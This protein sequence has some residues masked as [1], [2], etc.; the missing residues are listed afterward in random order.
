MLRS[1]HV[2]VGWFFCGLVCWAGFAPAPAWS[3]DS[4]KPQQPQ[5]AYTLETA[6]EQLRLYPKDASLQ[7]I[8][9]QLARREGRL[10]EV[11]TEFERIASDR[12]PVNGRRGDIDLFSIFTGALAVQE[13]LQLDTMRGPQPRA[14]RM[15]GAGQPAPNLRGIRNGFLGVVKEG[16]KDL[17][18]VA[19]LPGPTIKSHPWE[20][21][22][23]GQ[24][25]DVGQLSKLVPDDYFFAEFRSLNKCLDVLDSG[26][27]WAKH[28]LHQTAGEAR[29][30]QVGD[31]LKRQLAVESNPL[32]RPFYDL[33]VE[34]V[35]FTG[36]DLF[37][38]EGSD[39]T[40]LFRFKQPEVFKARMQGFLDSAEKSDKF[41]QRTTGQYQGVDYIHLS[42]YDR[43][44]HVY[45]AYPQPNLHVRSNSLTALQ[46]VLNSIQGKT[47]EGAV[48]R[49]LG[50]TPEFQYIRTLMKRGDPAEDGFLYLSDPFIRRL[51]GPTLK[52]TERR[53][54]LCYNHLRMI[55]HASLLYQSEHDH[56]PDSLAILEKTQCAP[57]LFGTGD[58]ACPDHGKYTLTADGTAGVCSV[59]GQA[60]N[61]VPCC[62]HPVTRVT[63]EEA[64]EY[65]A[66]LNAYNNYWRTFFDPIAIRIQA[67]PEQYRLETIIL[68]LIDNSI[69]Q[70]LATALGGTPEPLD[71]LPVPPRNIFSLNFRLDKT[72][73]AALAGITDTAPDTASDTAAAQPQADDARR[74]ANLRQIAVA[75]HNYHDAYG[76]FPATAIRS[77]EGKPLLSWRV[78]LLPYLENADL[79]QEF[80]LNEPWDSEHNKKLI[81]R[82]PAVFRTLPA[83][84]ESPHRTSYLAPVGPTLM[85]TGDKEG[86]K[87]ASVTDGTSNTLL[88][89]QADDEHAVT[90]TKPDDLVV[91]LKKPAANLAQHT[92]TGH[93]V[94]LADGA[95]AHLRAEIPQETLAALFTRNGSEVV[96][97]SSP[98]IVYDRGPENSGARPFW[99]W[100]LS[101]EQLA[102]LNVPRLLL[103]GLGNQVGLHAYDSTPTF[104]FNLPA[105]LGEALGTFSRRGPALNNEILPISFLI[106]SL[107]APVYASFAVQDTTIVDDFLGRLDRMLAQIAR[108]PPDRGWFRIQ[109]DFYRYQGTQGHDVR[110][111]SLGFGP[112]KFRLFWARI[113]QNL[114]ISSKAHILDDLAAADQA[115]QKAGTAGAPKPGGP[116]G[117]GLFAIRARNWDQVLPDYR[118]G[119]AEN[120]RHACLDNLGPLTTAA[121][122]NSVLRS[123]PEVCRC[124][125]Q[126]HG[127]HFFCPDGGHYE[128]DA[129]GRGMTCSAHGSAQTPRQGAAP[130]KDQALGKL[131]STFTG[132]EA[133]LTFLEDG[134]H[135]VVTIRRK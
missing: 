8:T 55:G 103:K 76:R 128:L 68:P 19:S 82:M 16:L 89:V 7:Y 109:N 81:E 106:A 11:F 67:T 4:S 14:D 71:G 132:L 83:K 129:A 130:A 131:L 108:Q 85:F 86:T 42:N 122:A 5:S 13:S 9:L 110:C 38:N 87:I 1:I 51:V 78:A 135:A 23:G 80:H 117:H 10:P 98:N 120:N 40:L 126:L 115:V 84:A 45:S 50:D 15:P 54:V 60:H 41:V 28:L 114:Y 66:F 74:V 73:L 25:P 133:T 37:F 43:T 79:Y 104:D 65:Q 121:R 46:R 26:D 72:N 57:G 24:H 2:A 77:P 31:R 58:L 62:E 90:W 75:L 56:S 102:R 107:N 124:A 48:V 97:L 113:G 105:F 34:D 33:V 20:Q 47:P 39:L 123:G 116:V 95:V 29:S 112:V 134:L 100:G 99:L 70:G 18:D 101:E 119:W 3:Q 49:R 17:V 96:D 36:S 111:Q 118:L 22:L 127:V 6:L 93:L 63:R 32:V 91:D 27:L 30:Q 59:H 35:A 94:L 88:L 44:V 12:L 64:T 52:L 125:D 53:R 21:M 61:L 92:N 69:Y